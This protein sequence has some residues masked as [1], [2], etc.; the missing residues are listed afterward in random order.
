MDGATTVAENPLAQAGVDEEAKCLPFPEANGLVHHQ[1]VHRNI[2]LLHPAD[3]L[4]FNCLRR[5]REPGEIHQLS[6]A[7]KGYRL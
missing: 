2:H 7:A 6:C 1:E 5:Q 3:Y 4:H